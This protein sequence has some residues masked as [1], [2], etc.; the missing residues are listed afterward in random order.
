MNSGALQQTWFAL[1]L[2]PGILGAVNYQI[3]TATVVAA[4]CK[5]EQHQVPT[6]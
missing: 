1:C 2:Q 3:S 4:S 6:S 5:S